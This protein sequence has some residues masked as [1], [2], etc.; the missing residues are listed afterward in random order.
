MKVDV[1]KVGTVDVYAPSEALAD[2][3]AES[4]SAMLASRIDQGNLRVV[5]S[6]KDV[7]YLDSIALEGLLTA[8]EKSKRHATPL[9]LASVPSTCRE[10]LELTGLSDHFQIFETTQDAV[11]SF[12]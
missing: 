4:F 6:L 5:V 12:M 11:R 1:Q 10:I 8:T 7:P 3:E 9:K 2:E